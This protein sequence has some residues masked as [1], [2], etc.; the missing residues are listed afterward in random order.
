MIKTVLNKFNRSIIAMVGAATLVATT[1]AGALPAS[2]TAPTPNANSQYANTSSNSV[3][4]IGSSSTVDLNQAN[5]G[6]W[7]ANYEITNAASLVGKTFSMTAA[8]AGLPTGYSMNANLDLTYYGANNSNLG[9]GSAYSSGGGTN[10][11]VPTNTTKINVMVSIYLNGGQDTLLPTATMTPSFTV[12]VAQNGTTTA[13]A[14]NN[15]YPYTGTDQTLMHLVSQPSFRQFSKTGDWTG[16]SVYASINSQAATCVDISGLSSG[17]QLVVTTLA[18]GAAVTSDQPYSEL[19]DSETS[20][21]SSRNITLT[22]QQISSGEM[23]KIEWYRS[24]STGVT[25]GNHSVGIS[26]TNNGTEVSAPCVLQAPT[27]SAPILAYQAAGNNGPA[28]LYLTVSGSQFAN[29][30]AW[31][32]Y[33]VSDNTL[34]SSGTSSGNT[35]PRQLYAPCTQSGCG[36][37]APAGVPVYAK[38]ST[39]KTILYNFSANIV[40]NSAQSSASNSASLPNPWLSVTAPSAGSA[41]GDARLV[42]ENIDLGAAGLDAQMMSNPSFFRTVSDGKNGI[43]RGN[44][45]VVS[46]CFAPTT[47]V[48]DAKLVRVGASG[49]DTTFGNSGANGLTLGRFTSDSNGM[50][51]MPESVNAGWYGARDKVSTVVRLADYASMTPVISYKLITGTFAGSTVSTLATL[52]QTDDVLPYCNANGGNFTGAS[53]NPISAPTS[54]PIYSLY[55]NKWDQVAQ[56]SVAVARIVSISGNGTIN[57][58]VKM[59]VGDGTT[60][61]SYTGIA[62]VANVNASAAGDVA[63]TWVGYTV[64]GSTIVQRKS[65]QIKVN[66][67]A[68]AVNTSPFS[69]SATT[70]SGEKRYMF[71]AT[72]AGASTTGVLAST[73]N[74]VTTYKMAVLDA[75]GTITDGDDLALDSVTGMESSTLGFVPGQAVGLTG[76][77]QMFRSLGVTKIASVTVDLDAKST[78]TGEVVTYANSTDVSVV[79]FF[80]LDPQGRMNWMFS[81]GANKLSLVRWNGVSGG[82]SLPDGV[83]VTSVSTKY[84]TTGA[85]VVTITGTGLAAWATG[86][87]KLSVV[88]AGLSNLIAPGTKSATKIVVTIPAGSTAGDIAI[89]AP[90]AAGDATLATVTRIASATKQSQTIED[91]AD[92]NATWSGVGSKTTATFP[93]ATDKGLA[94]TVKV[95]KAAICSVSG[96]TV[97]MNAAGTCVVTVASAGDLGTAAASN[98]TTIVV[99]KR[100]H[101]INDIITLLESAGTTWAGSNQTVT[102]PSLLTSVGLEAKVSVAPAAVCTLSAAIITLKAAGTCAVTV[103]GASDAGTDAIAKTVRNIIVAKGDIGLDVPAAFTLTNNPADSNNVGN[104]EAGIWNG[105]VEDTELTYSSSNEDIC[106]VDESGNVTGVAVG[107]CVITTDADGG[108][109]WVAEEATTTVTVEDSNTTVDVLPEVGDGNL[110]PKPVANN[111]NAFVVTNDPSL[112]V[113]WDKAAGLLTLQSK[114]VYIG[115]IKAEITF[116]KDGTQYTCTNIFGTTA[117]LAGKTAAQKKASLKT[118]VYTAT[119][120][121]CKDTSKLSVPGSISAPADFAKIAKAAKTAP[122]KAA[123]TLAFGKLKNFVGNMTI[124]VTRYRAWPTTMQNKA[125]HTSAGKGIPATIRSTVISL[126]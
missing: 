23:L 64:N 125:G 8:V 10:P 78:D 98:T 63:L 72:S 9:W 55:C 102:I 103:T 57:E 70:V 108:P 90:L 77:I 37:V 15:D 5:G 68:N 17:S 88:G 80:F 79:R 73:T 1:F 20:V 115:F 86:A 69:S 112:L 111:K 124:K 46:G 31:K 32:L 92:V 61:T 74:G 81:S 49:V 94:T 121:A 107:T 97:T 7:Q 65:V 34:V 35:S 62:A 11:T 89:N 21:G 22:S 19:L 110:S 52:S 106:T 16:H 59:N 60:D 93:A 18:D 100:T 84:I 91:T 30:W 12:N 51:P 56:V 85:A 104:I 25:S 76:K 66:G 40:I 43:L 36:V 95:D 14:R 123:E 48:I 101:Q 58:I 28:G 53:I 38:V 41:P 117:K 54:T 67:T 126:Q 44:I 87:S 118:K 26:V 45:K 4:T 119:A 2:A 71:S 13:V 105:A 96:Q 116:T 75:T 27:G 99:A 42:G 3:W 113:K 82:G 33:K 24:T 6:Y 83:T 39:S 50:G 120:A 29:S 122:E 109:N 47:C 114:G